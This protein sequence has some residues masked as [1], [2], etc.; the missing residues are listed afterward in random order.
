MQRRSYRRAILGLAA[1]LLLTAAAAADAPAQYPFVSYDAGLA[2]ARQ[3]SRRVFVYFGRE[4]CTWC[5][6]TNRQAFT[7]AKVREHYLAHY[8][9]VYVDS[10]GG[11]RLTLP[12]GERITE[13]ELGARLRAFAT[14]TFAW[15]EP[16]GK[17][18]FKVSGVQTAAD[19]LQYDRFVHGEIYRSKRFA[20][21]Q[22][23]SKAP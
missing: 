9:L 8:V 11:R 5:D 18:I 19:L 2:R 22:Q 7:D 4:G 10:E 20:D 12:S 16:D 17:L 15:L 21:F 23:E 14:P 6:L 1:G 13:A 3:E